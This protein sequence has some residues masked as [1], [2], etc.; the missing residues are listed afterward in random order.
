MTT[1]AKPYNV[2]SLVTTVT[3]ITSAVLVNVIP[4]S[5][6]PVS[7]QDTVTAVAGL[8]TACHVHVPAVVDTLLAKVFPENPSTGAPTLT[9]I[10]QKFLNVAAE[11]AKEEAKAAP[12]AP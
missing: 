6:I 4:G 5:H 12:S 3:A 2:K 9:P 8:L 7:L 1:P 11:L 10:Q